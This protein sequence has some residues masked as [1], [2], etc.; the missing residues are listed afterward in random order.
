M[1]KI[2]TFSLVAA[3]ALVLAACG[4]EPAAP[5]AENGATEVPVEEAT[6][7]ATTDEM[8]NEDAAAGAD[9][10]ATAAN[11]VDAAANTVEAANAAE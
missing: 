10:N 9:A 4:G 8:T 3:S 1:R 5:A 6:A 11:T 7:N 2:A